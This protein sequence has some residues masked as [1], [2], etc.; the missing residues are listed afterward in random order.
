MEADQFV[1]AVARGEFNKLA[2]GRQVVVRG[3]VNLRKLP[4]GK[5]ITDL[6][7]ANISGSLMADDS[8]ALKTCR[9]RVSG[10][11]TLDG[12]QIEE[13][14]PE[15]DRVGSVTGKFSAK[16]CKLLRKISGVYN[17][18]V[19]LDGSGIHE[20]GCDFQCM[21]SLLVCNC[22]NLRMVDCAAREIVADGSGLEGTGPNT[23]AENFSAEG[24]RRLQQATPINGLRWAN[25]DGSGITE[26]HPQF[27]CSGPAY[28]RRCRRLTSL[29]GTMRTVEVSTAPLGKV[30]G[31]QTG[32]AIFADCAALPDTMSGLRVEAAV[33]ARCGLEEIPDGISPDTHLRV[34]DCPRFSRLPRRWQ[35][36]I[37]L[38]GL[39][40]LTG[41]GEGFR[42]GGKFDVAECPN[43]S[44][45]SGVIAGDLYIMPDLP[46]LVELGSDLEVGGDLWIS[47]LA[48]VRSLGCRVEGSVSAKEGEMRESTVKFSVG[49][50]AVFHGSTKLGV[51]RGKVGGKAIL[52]ET[53]VTSLG[54]DFECGG[55]LS[56]RKT[57]K[58]ALLNCTVGGYTLV[59][60]S[61]LKSTGPAFHCG[62]SFTVRNCPNLDSIQGQ[63]DGRFR[64]TRGEKSS[65]KQGETALT[66][67]GLKKGSKAEVFPD[68][69]YRTEA[70][71]PGRLP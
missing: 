58:L 43:F 4:L 48:S 5:K 47:P 44:R 59:T 65:S 20:V 49:G 56:L 24:C 27:R 16:G 12:S 22:D 61:S 35:G 37:S 10:V 67:R 33:F 23:C 6:P 42:C 32:E 17:N 53:T 52:D 36:D 38:T 9:A 50:D 68:R 29:S 55:D 25:Y 41:T 19:C 40:K 30:S 13:F 26:V 39:P 28:F 1:Q 69:V 11:V 14:T 66:N 46:S 64:K 3:D 51:L 21:G 62:K 34:G 45:I 63:I 2:M 71:A 7:E 57:P 60:D 15:P 18:D 54:A 8:C 70:F 31:L